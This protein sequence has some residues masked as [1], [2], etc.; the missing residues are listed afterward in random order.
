M[1]GSDPRNQFAHKQA[2]QRG[3]AIGK[4]MDVRIALVRAFLGQLE[5]ESLEARVLAGPRV[6]RCNGSGL[7]REQV[8]GT[9]VE[10]RHRSLIETEVAHDVVTIGG[11]LQKL[12]F[13]LRSFSR[14]YVTGIRV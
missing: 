8:K 5:S 9:S 4:V 13:L 14:Q 10:H 6:Q 11:R 12:H 1:P 2:G 7:E 3:V